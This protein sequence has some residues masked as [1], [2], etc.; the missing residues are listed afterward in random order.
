MVQAGFAGVRQEE[1]CTLAL[2]QWAMQQQ[3]AQQASQLGAGNS[4][5]GSS[6]SNSSGGSRSSGSGRVLLQLASPYLN[7]A[8]PYES[9]LPGRQEASALRLGW[10]QLLQYAM[11]PWGLC[12]CM[13]LRFHGFL[14]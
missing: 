6:G 10:L 1:R 14:R 12:C 2:L 9:F 8:R 3:Q 4:G 11:A 7:L 13:V 5:P